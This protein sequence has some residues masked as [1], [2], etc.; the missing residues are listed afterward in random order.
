MYQIRL[1][2]L[3]K[4]NLVLCTAFFVFET[5]NTSKMSDDVGLSATPVAQRV[6]GEA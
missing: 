4:R 1:K 5:P 3:T 2:K 6:I